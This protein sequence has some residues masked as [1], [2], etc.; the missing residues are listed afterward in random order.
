MARVGLRLPAGGFPLRGW[1]F[2]ALAAVCLILRVPHLGGPLDLRFDAGVYYT[3]GMSL[4]E[5]KGYR[6]LSEPGE[7]GLAVGTPAY[8][9]PEQAAD[10]QGVNGR[11]L[12]VCPDRLADV[13]QLLRIGTW[14]IEHHR[15]PWNTVEFR[16]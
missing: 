15:E 8:M 6:I 12:Q 3:L 7:T 1:G 16:Y 5:G 13:Q 2:A 10:F 11:F 14:S 4:A 9:S